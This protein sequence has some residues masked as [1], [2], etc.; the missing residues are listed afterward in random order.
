MREFK[1]IMRAGPAQ[2][3]RILTKV[4]ARGAEQQ[5]RREEALA[6]AK[7]I[8]ID[9]IDEI[10]AGIEKPRNGMRNVCRA[11]RR[12]R[13]RNDPGCTRSMCP[14]APLPYSLAT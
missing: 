10:D 3:A 12:T 11:K 9:K 8:R 14:A 2:S 4:T 1:A 7:Q 13:R 6:R 5:R